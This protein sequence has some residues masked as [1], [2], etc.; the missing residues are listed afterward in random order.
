MYKLT[1]KSSVA[2]DLRRLHKDEIIRILNGIETRIPDNPHA[3][4]PL[5]GDFRGCFR[6]RFGDYRVIYTIVKNEIL[7]LRIGHRREIY[8]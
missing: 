5:T 4:K 3:G 7:I 6:Y 8:R 2:K 1:Y